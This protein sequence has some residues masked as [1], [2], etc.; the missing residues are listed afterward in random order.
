L[1]NDN[2]LY[3]NC[4]SKEHLNNLIKLCEDML[5]PIADRFGRDNIEILS[6]YRGDRLNLAITRDPNSTSQHRYGE[7]VDIR[8][9][10][11]FYGVG[12]GALLSKIEVFKT[13]AYDLGLNYNQCIAEEFT[14]DK[15]G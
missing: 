14:G 10:P 13:I 3:P 8:I 7:A 5:E 11:T 15:S 4:P 6:G 1:A 9:L 12:K 2:N